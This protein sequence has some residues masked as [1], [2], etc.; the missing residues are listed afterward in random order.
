MIL[1]PA[2]RLGLV[3]VLLVACPGTAPRRD[4]KGRVGDGPDPNQ[5]DLRPADP[6]AG[7]D[8]VHPPVVKACANGWCTIPPGCFLMGSPEWEDC[9]G[10]EETLHKVTLTHKFEIQDHEVTQKEFKD[11]MGYDSYADP[12]CV[13]TEPYNPCKGTFKSTSPA[14]PDCPADCVNW[15]EANAYCNELSKKKGLTPCY[16][17][18][19][20]HANDDLVCEPAAAYA[21]TKIYTCPGYRLPTEAEWEYAARAGTKTAYFAGPSTY[22]NGEA[23]CMEK[24]PLVDT[25]AWYGANSTDKTHPVMKLKANAWGLYDVHGNLWEWVL[26]STEAKPET[27]LPQTDPLVT[28]KAEDYTPI[29]KGGSWECFARGTRSANRNAQGKSD[30]G[31]QFGFRPVRT[32]LK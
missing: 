24:D 11:L 17:C 13:C 12:G 8:C 6:D 29:I 10:N 4:G 25:I 23:I 14:C 31:D 20:S 9:R 7:K 18:T 26:D 19:G 2:S 3:L 5:R 22:K 32:L 21:G 1:R 15:W 30:R 16:T 27:A 28:V